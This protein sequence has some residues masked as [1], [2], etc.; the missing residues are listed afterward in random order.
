MALE[1]QSAAIEYHEQ[2]TTGKISVVLTKGLT[3]QRDL[4]LAYSPGVAFACKAWQRA[5][6]RIS[7]P[8]ASSSPTSFTTPGS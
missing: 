7:T 4:A 8:T 2:P 5:R 3:N 6:S 1:L